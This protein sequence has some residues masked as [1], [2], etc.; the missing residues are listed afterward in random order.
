MLQ[1]LKALPPLLEA[2]TN[3]LF[4]IALP[5]FASRNLKL[6]ENIFGLAQFKGAFF[7]DLE[8]V[9]K[10]NIL[11]SSRNPN[12]FDKDLKLD[13]NLIICLQCIPCLGIRMILNL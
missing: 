2:L 1:F 8:C 10:G 3:D 6:R 11:D 5:G 13:A 4:K 7:G 12:L 9:G